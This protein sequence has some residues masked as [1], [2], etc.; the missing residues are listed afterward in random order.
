MMLDRLSGLET[1]HRELLEWIDA[2]LER[3]A[4]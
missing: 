3:G 4:R 2:W 1:E